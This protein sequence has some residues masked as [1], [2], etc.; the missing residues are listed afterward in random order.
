MGSKSD[1]KASIQY[2]CD[3]A[4]TDTGD[5][6]RITAATPIARYAEIVL[7]AQSPCLSSPASCQ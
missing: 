3:A 4:L 6:N 5:T 7:V 1:L 2:A